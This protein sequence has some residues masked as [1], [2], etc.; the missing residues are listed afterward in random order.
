[1]NKILKYGI[2]LIISVVI[3]CILW[4]L[5]FLIIKLIPSIVKLFNDNQYVIRYIKELVNE[6]KTYPI[7]FI[8]CAGIIN[9]IILSIFKKKKVVFY[10]VIVLINILLLIPII[11]FTTIDGQYIFAILQ[12]LKEYNFQLTF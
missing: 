9:F 3:A 4:L 1:M 10:I 2:N 11:L 12:E 7:A 6:D 5:T 8:C